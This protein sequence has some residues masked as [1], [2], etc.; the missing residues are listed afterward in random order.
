MAEW[1]YGKDNAQHGP[2][3][4]LEI[5]N[6]VTSGQIDMETIVWREGMG[7][8][9]PMKDVPDFQQAAGNVATTN[10]PYATPQ[11]YAGQAPYAGTIP[12]D[13]LSIAALV[14]G[15]LAVMSCMYGGLCGLPAV[16]CGHISLKKINNSPVP[17]QGKGMAIAG[18]VCGYLGILMSIGMVIFFVFAFSAAATA[19]TYGP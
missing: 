9:I 11:T 5:R 13:G 4:E 12:T 10:S 18:L 15:I 8:W 14:C 19:P 2:V 6:L 1:F 16:I 3:S 17:V 7:D